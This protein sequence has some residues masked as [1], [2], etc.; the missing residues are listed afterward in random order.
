LRLALRARHYSRRTEAA[1]VHWVRSFVLFHGKRHPSEM[2]EVEVNAFLTHLVVRR[3]VSSSTQNQALSALL[4]LYRH[5][6]GRQIGE[7]G[8]IVRARR[9]AAAPGG[10]AA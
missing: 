3:R 8:E 4:F 1:Y 9:P 7:L 6:L 5:L 10:I 2:A